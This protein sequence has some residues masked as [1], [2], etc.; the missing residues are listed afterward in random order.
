MENGIH[1]AWER[2]IISRY[3]PA[4]SQ[5]IATP[6]W[7]I[8]KITSACCYPSHL[9]R[10]FKDSCFLVRRKG[11]LSTRS[12][13][14]NAVLAWS[15]ILTNFPHMQNWNGATSWKWCVRIWHL[16]RVK[17]CIETVKVMIKSTTRGSAKKGVN[18]PQ[19]PVQIAHSDTTCSASDSL[20]G[21][22]HLLNDIGM[23]WISTCSKHPKQDEASQEHFKKLCGFSSQCA[24]RGGI[25][26]QCWY[27]VSGWNAYRV[28]RFNQPYVGK[29]RNALSYIETATVH[30]LLYL[31]RN[32]SEFR[33]G[34]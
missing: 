22:Y 33:A 17:F 2:A 18:S 8:P 16:M 9:S 10:E 11:W 1:R 14:R 28:T 24:S 26:R 7:V 20:G 34:C 4:Y 25:A 30:L 23:S 21:L 13:T 3:R 32:M 19:F 12:N 27:L 5:C 6:I 15:L 31:W 29:K